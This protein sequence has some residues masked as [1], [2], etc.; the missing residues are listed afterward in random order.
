VF[1][2]AAIFC[3][4]NAQT[5]QVSP[6]TS[7]NS[8]TTST[9]TQQ[10]SLGWGSNIQ[11]ARLARAAQ[12][13]LQQGHREQA[14][15]LAQ[16]AT[17]AAPND[18]QLWFL[19]GYA[20]RLN[21]RFDQSVEAYTRGLRIN[22]SAL[23]GTSGL[24]Q[25]YSAMGKNDE[26]ERLLRQVVSSD[27]HRISDAVLLGDIYLRT[28]D[29]ANAIDILERAEKIQPGA[30]AELLLA[31]AYHQTKQLDL[32]DHYL[33]M[34]EQRDPG[35]PDIQRSMAGYDRE[36]GKYA[37]AIELL[38][39][40]HNPKP[41]VTAELAYTYQLDGKQKESTALYAQAAN[42]LPKDLN[43]QLSA[44]QGEIAAGSTEES[45]VFLK[46]AA[47]IDANN[48]RLHAILGELAKGQERPQDAVKQY[49]A[50]IAALPANPPEGRLYGIQLHMDLFT[51]YQQVGEHDASQQQLETA[52][53]A[54]KALDPSS[55]PRAQFLR[56]RALIRSNSGELDG[57]MA[58]IKEALA[59]NASDPASLQLDGDILM[60]LKRPEDAIQVYKQILP[61]DP[62]NRF[63]LTALGDASRAAGRN[64]DAEK[65]F[66]QLERVDPSYYV[67]Y[68]ALGDLYTAERD[69][70]K[71]QVS[72]R[73]GYRL[74]PKNAL[75]VA[76][77]MNAA[78]EAHTLDVAKTWFER[79]TSE[80]ANEPQVLREKE[81]YLS[82][83]GR[84]Q[85]SAEIGQRALKALPKDRDVVVYLGYDYLH[86]GRYDDLLSLT[87]SYHDVLAREPDI[88]LLQGYVHKHQGLNEQAE[89]DFTEVLD[90][91]PT[92]VTAYVNRGYMRNDL[93]RTSAAAS[94]FEEALHRE[95]NDGEAHLGLAY[96]NLDLSKPQA[97]LRQAELAEKTLGDSRDIHVIRATAYGR[98]D[99]L[100]RAASEYRAALRYT[101]NDGALHLGLANSLFSLR[102]YH[103]A[104]AELEIAEQSL[105]DN[106]MIEAMLARSYANL[107]ERE[108]ALKNIDAAEAH[109]QSVP[110]AQ[111]SDLYVS[112]G[113]AFSTLGDQSNAMTR[114]RKA[115]EVPES[116]RIRA[117][118]AIAEIMSEEGQF[119]DANRQ[120]ALGWM[121]AAAG[122]TSPPTGTELLAAADVFRATHE[123]VLSES[124]LQHAK[125]SGAPDV[126][127]RVGLANTYL[128][129]G[130]TAK[131][132][133]E[134]AAARAQ[135]DDTSSYQYLLAQ[136][137]V[138]QQEH[139]GAQAL[140][141]FAQASNAE[142]D[143]Q[144]VEQSMLLA[145]ANEG[146]R[147][148]PK[149]S[150]L[151]DTSLE[152]VYEDSTVYVLDS[153]LDASFP[154]P[155]SDAALLPPPRSSLATQSTEAF[156]LHFGTVPTPGGFFQV[157]NAEGQISVPATNSIVNRNT[158]DY[159]FNI[160]LSPVV[161]LGSNVA[162]F[163]G[164]IQETIRRDTLSPVEMNQNLFREF[165]YMSTSSFFNALSVSG[166]V[167][168][169]AGPFTES[170]LHSSS[171]TG[172]LDFRVSAPWGKTALLTGWGSSDQQFS[173]VNYENYYTSSY[174]GLE[175][176][177]SDRLNVRAMVEDLRSW[178][179]VGPNSGIAQ[180][181]RPAGTVD[182]IPK[183]N[184]EIQVTSSYSSTRSF[185]IYDAIQNGFAI[186]YE[187][188]LQHRF[189]DE[190]GPVLL[191]YPIR[192]S[193]GL[194]DE[195][196]FNFP[197]GRNQQLRPYI[198]V[199]LF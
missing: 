147:I 183:R 131:A 127:V 37:D 115:L 197:G 187:K 158:T 67:S 20:A 9:Q 24:A 150:L 116:D 1:V 102:H 12:M 182:F 190:S 61:I 54:L 92:V 99:L 72:Y 123:Y 161:H 118:L 136:A 196:F 48:Y 38:R 137:N 79:A 6:D 113:E 59:L 94:D 178:R 65:Y 153:K 105:P 120:I 159:T 49:R 60:K 171:L 168:H 157:R 112:T 50:A 33:H 83:A 21:G 181:L 164:G 23:E 2:S 62:N 57:A 108:N 7:K 51:L 82:F 93:H 114:F 109:V 129:L 132:Q 39:S 154:V 155:S 140:T 192:F 87:K 119:E 185:H 35:N 184:W 162:I 30:R 133:A 169:E 175:R 144:S 122:D 189:S 26:A 14:L 165:M 68:L 32:A 134:L 89:L 172:E 125:S 110:A 36:A 15:E 27:P 46:R 170:N 151:S 95:P 152:P 69:F 198:Q 28:R 103:D 41:D 25:D 84:Y 135:G 138:F 174:I 5:Y 141:S 163:N 186:S 96:A 179:V 104:I 34:A 176:R 191:K 73:E 52:N 4:A 142:G 90:R 173:P 167:I 3:T 156:H 188:P 149:L 22:P 31:L 13:A 55:E 195:T 77:G 40:I 71:A 85:E 66:E 17:E 91:D 64:Q 76:G 11:N 128:A 78:I 126:E 74:A 121:E 10:Q 139:Q 199:T 146:Y 101:P 75:I 194:Q 53:A 16:R 130:E 43:L 180:N 100:A 117:R 18:P 80:M 148:T 45:N 44:A 8:G 160:G 29:F 19:L 106:A 177:F 70:A 47:T 193:A 111:R 166:F 145:G 56:L 86:L 63:A 58:D 81:R 98:E 124:Y 143:D 107:D 88:P 97:A 42:A